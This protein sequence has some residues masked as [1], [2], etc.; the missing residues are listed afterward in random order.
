MPVNYELLGKRIN[1]F[2][3][4]KQISQ[5]ALGEKITIGYKHIG[6]IE[7]AKRKPSLDVIVDIANALGVSADDLLSDSL[8]HSASTANTELHLLLLDCTKT[9]VEIITRMARELK[10]ILYSQ[11]I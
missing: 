9:E 10:A 7:L 2:R 1:S 5:E 8:E 3:I 6:N 11:G 4:A